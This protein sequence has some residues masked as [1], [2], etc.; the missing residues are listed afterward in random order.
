MFSKISRNIQDSTCF[1]T[2]AFQ[3]I[4]QILYENLFLKKF[5]GTAFGERKQ[6]IFYVERKTVLD[7]IEAS[8]C[9]I[10]KKSWSWTFLDIVSTCVQCFWSS[11]FKNMIWKK[12][13]PIYKKS[14]KNNVFDDALSWCNFSVQACTLTHLSE[15][16][17]S[18]QLQTA[19][20]F[21]LYFKCPLLTD[22]Y[23]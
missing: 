3:Q 23:A 18:K 21:K 1:S 17:F 12:I 7:I 4:L 11:S 2:D 5:Q 13:H 9:V 19:L 15:D 20:L 22:R 16:L 10:I 6:L 14:S 8:I